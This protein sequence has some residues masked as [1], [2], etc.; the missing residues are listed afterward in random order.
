MKRILIAAIVITGSAVLAAAQPAKEPYEPGLGE[1]M[2][3]TQL[4]HTKL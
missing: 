3:A 2:A 4:R 1:F